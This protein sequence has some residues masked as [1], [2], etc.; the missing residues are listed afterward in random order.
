M[1]RVA[2]HIMRNVNEEWANYPI[3]YKHLIKRNVW[4]TVVDCY[5]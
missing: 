5:W 3:N 2:I 4:Y 1:D